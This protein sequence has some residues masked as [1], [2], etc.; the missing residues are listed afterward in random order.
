VT[1]LIAVLALKDLLGVYKNAQKNV[2]KAKHFN[3]K[4]LIFFLE[5]FYLKQNLNVLKGRKKILKGSSL[6]FF[7]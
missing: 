6:Q 1:L 5:K 3:I 4:K 7:N 2:Q